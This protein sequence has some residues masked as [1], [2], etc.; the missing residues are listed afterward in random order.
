M[1]TIAIAEDH[2][3]VR[4]GV[5]ALLEKEP[6][7]RI[8]AEAKDGTEAIEKVLQTKPNILLLDLTLPRLHGLNVLSQLRDRRQLKVVVLSMHRD[9]ASVLEALRLGAQGYVLK[10]SPPSELVGA[11]RSVVRNELFVSQALREVVHR[12]AVG[13][14]RGGTA[15]PTGELTRREHMV[16]Q[17]A[18]EGLKND[19][20]ATSLG[21]S[22][23]TAEKHRA[24]VMRK[25][26]LHS[27][28]EL[29]R[30]AIRHDLI[31]T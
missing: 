12:A 23:R 20:I 6:D 26:Q 1:I 28:G 24:N 22:V 11:I 29:L 18:A 9:N 16:L 25:L 14:L 7:F 31:Q 2:Q 27:Q 21:I 19:A 4:E 15:K 10:D 8:V 3:I 5:R 17:L 30:Y 13:V